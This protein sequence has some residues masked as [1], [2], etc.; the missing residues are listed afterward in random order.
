MHKTKT[1]PIKT[2]L[3][4]S[5]GFIVVFLITKWKWAITISL[6]VGLAGLSSDFL[7]KK[8]DFIWMKLS[9]VLS[10]IVPNIIL[11]AIFYLFL[12]PVSLLYKAISQND[13]LMLKNNLSSTFINSNKTFTKA[14]FEKSW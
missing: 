6:I 9:W 3:T 2:V 7:S 13:P 11:S 14:S 8:I 12:F 5:V 4:I 1:D 10:L